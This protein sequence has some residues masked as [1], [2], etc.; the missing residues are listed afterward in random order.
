MTAAL[1]IRKQPPVGVSTEMKRNRRKK[2][3][4]GNGCLKGGN[5]GVSLARVRISIWYDRRV[6]AASHDKYAYAQRD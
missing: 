2:L 4:G 1:L 5:I 6:R 3:R